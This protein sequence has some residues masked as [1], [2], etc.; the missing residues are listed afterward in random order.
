[1]TRLLARLL[2]AAAIALAPHAA[3]AQSDPPADTT[4][5]KVEC[6]DTP[7]PD[8]SRIAGMLTEAADRIGDWYRNAGFPIPRV[9]LTERGTRRLIHLVPDPDPRTCGLAHALGC[10]KVLPR[11]ALYIT[12]DRLDRQITNAAFAAGTPFIEKALSVL[13]HTIVHEMFHLIQRDTAGSDFLYADVSQNTVAALDGQLMED[14]KG[15]GS[16]WLVE[17]GAMAAELAW[18][19]QPENAWQRPHIIPYHLELD[20]PLIS[21][22]GASGDPYRLGRF[23][24]HLGAAYPGGR[25]AFLRAL[26]QPGVNDGYNGLKHVSALMAAQGSSLADRFVD[27]V[28]VSTPVAPDPEGRRRLALAF[29]SGKRVT[30]HL[31]QLRQLAHEWTPRVAAYAA[32]AMVAD[33]QPGPAAAMLPGDGVQTV[34]IA[35]LSL[36]EAETAEDLT[37]IVN[38]E[39]SPDL[40][41]RRAYAEGDAPDR[42]LARLVNFSTPPRLETRAQDV[43]MRLEAKELLLGPPLCV[44]P[45]RVASIHANQPVAGLSWAVEAGRLSV[46]EVPERPDDPA[47]PRVPALVYFAPDRP[48]T[49][50]ITLRTGAAN[51]PVK[52][53]EIVVTRYPCRVDLVWDSDESTRSRYVFPLP[54]QSEG[55]PT[56]KELGGAEMVIRTAGTR[57]ES[58]EVVGN[59]AYAAMMRGN[60]DM[61]SGALP[62][63]VQAELRALP[64]SERAMAAE[65][66]RNL[67]SVTGFAPGDEVATFG[68]PTRQFDM[69]NP[70][71]A[72]DGIAEMIFRMLLLDR[73]PSDAELR[74]LDAPPMVRR[75]G[76]TCPDTRVV[77]CTR[78]DWDGQVLHYNS[79][80]LLWRMDGE[81]GHIE[82][83]HQPMP[84]IREELFMLM[85]MDRLPW[86]G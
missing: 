12:L 39:V 83:R 34:T 72:V 56:G 57:L 1:M 8:F 27:F 65:A 10:F 30:L 17:G 44:L 69:L 25:M 55:Q 85:V 84:R 22:G 18:V 20:R 45:G 24:D 28:R 43:K 48:G 14:A 26:H 49:Y 47:S 38:D 53:A 80:G 73:L 35:R 63:D 59:D 4:R 32:A 79:S 66:M 71:Q 36:L 29:H 76:Q 52:V 78:I 61:L 67:G 68:S 13:T 86:E 54:G 33:I 7:C 75:G 58:G 60:L 62:P 6:T 74:R 2:A 3:Q 16:D 50:A 19:A 64:S 23:L 77:D 5:W 41:Y 81:D 40:T 42:W 70:H 21:P 37:L 46:G 15:R 31:P 82:I 11:P 51:R 9:D